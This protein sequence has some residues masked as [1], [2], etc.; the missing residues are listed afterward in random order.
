MVVRVADKSKIMRKRDGAKSECL[1]P[2]HVLVMTDR[3]PKRK[4]RETW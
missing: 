2:V 3:L 4:I 1:K